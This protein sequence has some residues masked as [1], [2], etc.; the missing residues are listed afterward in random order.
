MPEI[1]SKSWSQ[2]NKSRRKLLL[3]QICEELLYMEST[4]PNGKLPWG[5]V[6]NIVK[7]TQGD[8]PWV[9][10]NIINFAYKK[11]TSKMKKKSPEDEATTLS[12]TP[13]KSGGRQKGD[14]Y[15]LRKHRKDVIAAAKNEI[16]QLYKEEKNRSNQMGKILPAGW[17]KKTISNICTNRG[18][19]EEASS[20]SLS[21]I[22]NRTNCMIRQ[23]GGS[24]TLMS[25]VE[26]HLVE[27][28]CAMAHIRRCL[29]TTESLALANDLIS[30][31]IIEEKIINW[32]KK[33]MEYDPSSPVLGKKYW[34]LFKKRWSHKLVT[35]RGQ[36]F[37][38]DR[39]NALTYSNVKQMYDQVYD[40]MV[41]A[42]VARI[43][44]EYSEEYP[45]PLKTRY[46]LTHP[47]MCLVVD[48]V[49]SSSCQ[50]GDGHIGGQ[51]YLCEQGMV[52]QIQ[53]SHSNERHFTTLGF[54]S[55]SGH[56]VL[57]L[58][59]IAGVREMYEIETGIDIEA[60][61]VGHPSDPDYFQ[62]NRGKGKLFPLGPECVYNGKTIPCMVRWSPNGSITSEIL[63]DA[64]C[65]LDHHEVFERVSG[66]KPFLLLASFQW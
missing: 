31:T 43:S 25:E 24:E 27:L 26:P 50:R 61:V 58:I 60:E 22:R 6:T 40:C 48:E 34:M 37:A 65:T 33:R 1:K 29:T 21:T 38:M 56:P 44:N 4:S 18:I 41:S 55:L 10:R 16:T 9:T 64:L 14:T 7:Q 57:C 63:R 12:T 32:K 20:I 11:Y 59:I 39:S 15:L 3:N 19:P 23:G 47:E 46:H 2:T 17:L 35:M 53:A 30:E 62:K 54:T 51:K 5:S 36:K 66:R 42:G 45:G 28:I 13:T 49:G 8:N 52:P